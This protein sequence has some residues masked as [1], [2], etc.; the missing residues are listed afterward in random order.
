MIFGLPNRP[1]QVLKFLGHK[2]YFVNFF[3]TRK[4]QPFFL[5]SEKDRPSE[6]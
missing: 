5:K 2:S 3:L 4:M 6:K 1:A